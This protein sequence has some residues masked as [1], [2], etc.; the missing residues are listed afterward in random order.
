MVVFTAVTALGV[1]LAQK[2]PKMEPAELIC[3]VLIIWVPATAVHLY[4]FHRAARL[5]TDP[6]APASEE[7]GL[8]DEF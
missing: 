6:T 8:A 3:G 4:L 7:A 5:P 2:D 1:I